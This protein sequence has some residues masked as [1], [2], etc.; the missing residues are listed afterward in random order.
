[1]NRVTCQAL[2]KH[3]PRRATLR[4]RKPHPDPHRRLQRDYFGLS[5]VCRQVRHEYRPWHILHQQIAIDLVDINKY[6]ETFYP[7][8]ASAHLRRTGNL[9]IAIRNKITA[10]EKTGAGLDLWPPLSL[11]A[12]SYRVEANFGRYFYK[13][14]DGRNDGNSNDLYHF[15]CRQLQDDLT[16]DSCNQAWLSVLAGQ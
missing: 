11:W 10:V 16:L 6:I 2:L 1:M 4:R 13:G 3:L 7:E 14:C 8:D 15:F 5:Q 12:K 9:T